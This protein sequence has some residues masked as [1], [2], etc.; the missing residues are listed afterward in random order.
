MKKTFFISLLFILAAM[1]VNAQNFIKGKITDAQSGEA[2]GFCNVRLYDDTLSSSK[3]LG[4][5]VSNEKGEYTVE[6]NKAAKF[7]MFS[8]VG[9]KDV[10]L[11]IKKE[12]KRVKDTLYINDVRM[13]FHSETLSQIEIFAQQKRFEM[14]NDGVAMNVDQDISSSTAN[15]FELLRKVPGVVIDKDEN[16]QLN[17]KSGILF[18]FDGRDIRIPYSAIRSMLKSMSPSD[19]EKIETI[20]NPSAK[21]EAE[22]TAGI[23]NIKFAKQESL[24]WSGEANLWTA[25]AK[26]WKHNE[27]LNLN[28]VNEK[29]TLNTSLSENRWAGHNESESDVFILES[30]PTLMQTEKVT[31]T[32]DYRGYNANI[33]A[34]YKINDKSSLGAMFSFNRNSSPDSENPPVR[35]AIYPFPYNTA[36]SSYLSESD[37]HSNGR[38]IAAN[39]WYSRKTD[40]IGGQYSITLDYDNNLSKDYCID[41]SFYYG[42]Y[43]STF[44]HEGSDRDSTTNKYNT[45][46]A[47]F[48]LIKPLNRNISFEAGAKTRLTKVSNDFVCYEDDV[49]SQETSNHLNYTENVNALYASF[50]D[51]ISDKLSL[52]LGL[53]AEHTHTDIEQKVNNSSKSRSYVDLFPN[54][55]LNYKIGQM[56]NLTL[57]YSYRITRPEYNTMNPFMEKDN[58][59]NYNSG[60]PN[61]KPQYTHGLNLSYAFHY[62]LFLTATYDYT[63]DLISET[64]SLMPGTLINL[65]QPKNLGHSQHATLGL[66]TALPLGKHLEWTIWMQTTWSEVK[67]DDP[68]LKVDVDRFGFMTWQSIKTDFLFKT[69]LTLSAFYMTGGTQGTYSF[70]DMFS[71][72]LN[73]SR[74]FM[75]NRLKTSIGVGS[76]PKRSFVINMQSENMTSKQK[77]TWQYPM[78]S[79]SLSYTFGK[80]ADNNTLQRIK[81]SDMDER[82]S[83]ENSAGQGMGR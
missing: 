14:T 4:G 82:T 7:I 65:K 24:G 68:T 27:G 69:K 71:F 37:D 3:L 53:R 47:K 55:N 25:Y 66:S 83:G 29:W 28:Y 17:G 12:S 41:R 9:Y 78:V 40:S 19:I 73:L 62:F 52:R 10:V 16:I 11:E 77:M 80:K 26:E 46:S 31:K 22:G 70:G 32:Y 72:D 38:N 75:Q 57:V 54:V 43:F 33:S 34:D 44:D 23:I 61:L 30:T 13:E 56:D 50:S 21:Y 42:G 64:N 36:T 59:Y 63:S 8:F 20:S 39:L 6:N 5:G 18:Q 2:V 76:L 45:F 58:E 74:Q 15:A 79:F 81:S 49:F 67:V 48:D 1:G 60:N 35:T 51:R